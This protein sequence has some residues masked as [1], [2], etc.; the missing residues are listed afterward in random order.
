M[1]Q[2]QSNQIA[3]NLEFTFSELALGNGSAANPSIAFSSDPNTGLFSVGPDVLGFSTGGSQRLSITTSTIS[4]SL[5]FRASD[6]SATAP[7]YSFGSEGGLGWYRGGAAR[8]SLASGTVEA[9]FFDLGTSVFG[10]KNNY[11]IQTNV[12]TS[13]IPGYS[14]DGDANTGI[15]RPL[16]DVIGVTLGG[17]QRGQ[18]EGNQYQQADGTASLPA[19]SFFNDT[20][21]GIYR[22]GTDRVG[23]AANGTLA[24]D[25]TDTRLE[26]FNVPLWLGDGSAAAPSLTFSND[27]DT[28]MYRISANQLGF[29]TG[30][31]QRLGI[32]TEDFNF[33]TSSNVNALNFR[34]EN[35]SVTVPSFTFSSDTDTGIYRAN[36]NV[37]GFSCA[38][39]SQVLIT[40]GTMQFENGNVIRGTDGTASNPMFSFDNDPDTGMYRVGTNSLGFAAGGVIKASYS[41]N[42]WTWYDRLVPNA[43]NSYAIGNSV[44]RWTAIF[45]VNGTIQTSHSSTKQNIVDIDPALIE[46]PRGVEFDRDGRRFLGYLNDSVPDTGRPFDDN[47][48]I[49]KRDNYEQ[50]VIGILCAK[51]RYLE[52][53]L[54]QLL[55]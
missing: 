7:V 40:D 41:A 51:V 2:I 29:A 6:G 24:F 13:S 14:F 38:A 28:G 9:A 4:P 3:T 44:E 27:P 39:E 53:K 12:G 55:G 10:L 43:D 26:V 17:T 54:N 50:A 23:F 45:A 37:I 47:G 25:Y 19:F 21:T 32:T 52:E 8:M 16:A 36:T 35:G 33:S 15:Y 20:D 11:N 46:V 1:P 22:H 18:W 34:A 42:G 31:V 49:C 48:Q 30:G 5:P